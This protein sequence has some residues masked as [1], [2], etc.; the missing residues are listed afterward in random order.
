MSATHHLCEACAAA[1]VLRRGPHYREFTLWGRICLY[2]CEAHADALRLW[3]TR[4]KLAAL[5]EELRRWSPRRRDRAPLPRHLES[6]Q[7]VH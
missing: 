4:L 3:T 6:A 5:H 1:G 2:L 7:A